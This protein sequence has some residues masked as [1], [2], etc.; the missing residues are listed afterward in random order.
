MLMRG[1]KIQGEIYDKVENPQI[2]IN[3]K[4][5]TIYNEHLDNWLQG[6]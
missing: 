3:T 6:L 4:M 1:T 5:S 2:K